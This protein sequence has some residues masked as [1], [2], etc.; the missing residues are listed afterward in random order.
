LPSRVRALNG[1]RGGADGGIVAGSITVSKA[2]APCAAAL[3]APAMLWRFP[4][5]VPSLTVDDLSAN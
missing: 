1:E 4:T 2:V 3:I 5:I